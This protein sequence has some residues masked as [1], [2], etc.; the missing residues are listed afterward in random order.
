MGSEKGETGMPAPP[1][2]FFAGAQAMTLS[3]A[4]AFQASRRDAGF[5]F[6]QT[7]RLMLRAPGRADV[8]AIAQLAADRRIAA[9]TTR[10][11][12]PYRRRRR[13]RI[14][15]GNQPAGR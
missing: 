3:D 14:H 5:Q 8:K 10:I 12:H 13:R 2:D 4:R 11:P 6:S 15:R 7:E 1:F 9:N